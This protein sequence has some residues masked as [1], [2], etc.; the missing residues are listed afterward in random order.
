VRYFLAATSLFLA[1]ALWAQEPG[2]A[3]GPPPAF[4]VLITGGTVLDGTGT[5]RVRAD[6]GVKNGRIRVVGRLQGRKATR[7]I[8]A[9]GLVVAPGFIDVHTHADRSAIRHPRAINFLRMGVTSLITGN[10]G[11]S[12]LDLKKHFAQVEKKGISLNYG[13]LIGHNTVRKKVMKLADRAPTPEEL[14]AMKALVKQGMEAGAMGLSTGLIYLPGT[15]ARTEELIQL[16][17]VVA[18]Y[19]GVYATHMRNEGRGVLKSIDEAVRIGREAGCAVQLSHLKACG[20]PSWGLGRKIVERMEQARAAGLRVT[21]DQYAY[22]ATSTGLDILFPARA[23]THGRKAFAKKLKESPAFREKMRAA[24]FRTMKRNGVPDLAYCRIAHAPRN[25]KYNGMT[26]K[27]AALAE[28]NRGDATHQVRMAIKLFIE[29][30]GSRVTMVYHRMC[31]KDV[32]AIM[33]AP[34]VCVACDAGIRTSRGVGK[35]HPRGGGNNARV[36]GRYVRDRKVL[37]LPLAVHKMTGLPAG[38]FGLEDRG[39]IR[40]DAWADIT[41]FDPKTIGGRAT[42]D[43]PREKPLGIPYVLVAGVVVLDKGKHTGKLP[44]KV[45]RHQKQEKR[46]Q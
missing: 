19:G 31:E 37:S 12:V 14:R 18:A 10:C 16:S 43:R 7:I 29:S 38:I 35:P 24:I 46:G 40:P 8:D 17:R 23:R 9:T 26:L 39:V 1:T 3:S 6:V 42:Y 25:T 27:E 21:G 41:L 22:K 4:D 15:F 28:W 44:G 11:G 20:K 33:K 5:A 36:L 34:F 45:L 13:S 2:A 32:K 30:R